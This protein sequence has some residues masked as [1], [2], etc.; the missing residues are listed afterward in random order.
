MTSP[1]A[2]SETNVE[3][4]RAGFDSFNANDLDACIDQL[5]PDFVINLAELPEPLRGREVWR[6]G[7]EQMKRAFP[8]LTGHIEDIFAAGDRV[9]VRLRFLGTHAGEFLGMPATG[10]KVEY[11]SHEFYRV[12]DGVITEEWIC[13]DM[14]SLLRQ[15]TSSPEPSEGIAPEAPGSAASVAAAYFDAWKGKDIER[16]RPLLHEDVSFAGALGT[17][18]G[19]EETLAGLGGMFAMTDQV[20]VVHRWV[21]GPDVLTWF[22]LRSDGAGPMSIVNWSHVQEGRITRIRVTFDPR[23]LL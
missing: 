10:R 5:A 16:V 4:V 3:L 20:E 6:E 1:H 2:P 9:A 22:E 18:R 8:E 12:V 7:V 23:P 21:D 19:L 11:V 17:T 15:L 14:A 13:S